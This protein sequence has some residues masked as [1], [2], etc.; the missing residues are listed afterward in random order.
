MRTYCAILAALLLAGCVSVPT[1]E[2][3]PVPEWFKPAFD[4]LAEG[5]PAPDFTLP[6]LSAHPW[7][8]ADQRGRVIVLMFASNSDPSY[9]M[10]LDALNR[11]VAGP[12]ADRDGVRI[13][14]VYS[15]ESHPELANGGANP[16]LI[17]PATI[18]ERRLAASQPEYRLRFRFNRKDYDVCGKRPAGGNCVALLDGIDPQ[19]EPVAGKLYG[20]GRGGSTNPVF[21]IDAQGLLV[22]KSV[23]LRDVLAPTGHRRGNLAETVRRLLDAPSGTAPPQ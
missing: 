20:Y 10:A 15:Q 16:D 7:R 13:V 3:H 12:F 6:D 14:T 23:W 2:K 11:E 21:V 1:A 17:I 4:A 18:E 8:L 9:V 19:G 22:L 5:L